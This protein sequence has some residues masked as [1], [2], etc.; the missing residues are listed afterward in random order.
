MNVV[1][2]DQFNTWAS[3]DKKRAVSPIRILSMP[4]DVSRTSLSVTS[5][6]E[7]NVKTGGIHISIETRDGLHIQKGGLNYGELKSFV[8]RLEVLC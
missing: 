6:S 1:P 2:Y 5:K 7:S 4:L 3:Q 8:E